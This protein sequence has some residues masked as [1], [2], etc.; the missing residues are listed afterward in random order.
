MRKRLLTL[1]AACTLA[2]LPITV[3]AAGSEQAVTTQSAAGQQAAS[4]GNYAGVTVSVGAR[5]RTGPATPYPTVK[6]LPGGQT[7]RF[8]KVTDG[9][10][11]GGTNVWYFDASDNGW[12]SFSALKWVSYPGVL[13]RY[14]SQGPFVEEVQ[15]QLNRLGYHSGTVDGIFGPQ[16]LSAVRAFQQVHGLTADG[17]V[18]PL[19]WSR[20]FPK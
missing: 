12:I 4:N 5:V 13:V 7:V 18:G 3:V 15:Y 9:Q 10:R 19:T 1:A 17:I 6:I 8:T 2:G 16:T 14:G 11:V 20:L